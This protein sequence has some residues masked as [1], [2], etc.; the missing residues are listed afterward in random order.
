MKQLVLFFIAFFA[1]D[2]GIGLFL[3]QGLYRYYGL[4]SS[5]EMALVGHSHLMLGT[6]KQSLEN[7]LGLSVAKYTREGVNVANRA[8]MI[9]QLLS[10]NPKTQYVVYGVDAWMLTGEGLSEN[11]H[12]LFYPFMG[13]PQVDDF[14]QA[15]TSTVEFW[16]KK[17]LKTSRF[18]EMLISGALRG[19]LKNWDNLKHGTVDTLALKQNIQNGQYRTIN[20]TLKNKAIF[21][22]TLKLLTDQNI[23]VFLV[24]VPTISYY[25]QAEPEQFEAMLQYFKWLAASNQQLH[26]LEFLYGWDTQHQYFF[27]PIHLNPTGQAAFSQAL[28]QQLKPLLK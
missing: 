7:E 24:Y 4:N 9:E 5:A 17:L 27:D 28:A 8:V 14:V 20:S 6:N 2:F 25:N 18:D 3:Q 1:F 15:E 12:K 13:Q 11:S 16:Q 10:L 23:Q 21:E 26:Y 22:N 19:Y